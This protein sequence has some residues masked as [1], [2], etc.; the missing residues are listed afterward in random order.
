LSN[1]ETEKYPFIGNSSQIK[2]I[3]KTLEILAKE[4]DFTVLITGETGVGKEVAAAI[5]IKKESEV[6][7]LSLPFIFLQSRKHFWKVLYSD[8]KRIIH[9]SRL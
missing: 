7:N 2:E 5:F 1:I 8:I 4:S 6:K 9:R 3:K